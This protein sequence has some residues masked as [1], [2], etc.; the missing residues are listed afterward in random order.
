MACIYDS[1]GGRTVVGGANRRGT[2]LA[3]AH[4]RAPH[5]ALLAAGAA[6]FVMMGGLIV[7]EGSQGRVAAYVVSGIGFL[8]G[9]VILKDGMTIRGLNTA[10]TLWCTAAIGTLSGLGA[11][12]FSLVEI[13]AIIGANVLLR[14]LGKAINR[15]TNV[16]D[17]EISYL[18]RIMARADQ[19]SHM[20]ALLLQSLGGQPLLLRSLKSEDVRTQKSRGLRKSDEYRPPELA[21][22]TTRESFKPRAWSYRSELGNCR[23]ARITK[24]G[25]SLNNHAAF[26]CP[27]AVAN[28]LRPNCV[29]C[30]ATHD[31]RTILAVGLNLNTIPSTEHTNL[32]GK[33]AIN[34]SLGARLERRPS[35]WRRFQSKRSLDSISPFRNQSLLDLGPSQRRSPVASHVPG[36]IQRAKQLIRAGAER[37][38]THSDALHRLRAHAYDGSVR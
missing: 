16:T 38:D 15:E 3:T 4:G 6:M 32:S 9:G 12:R 7:G 25:V 27:T 28:F 33:Y 30:S 35:G 26:S 5:N 31:P 19:E 36:E 1:P 18:F 20:R 11:A 21:T 22:G 24:S 13:F 37:H 8:G 29:P 14:P 23:G 17:A 34:H 2:P 10:A